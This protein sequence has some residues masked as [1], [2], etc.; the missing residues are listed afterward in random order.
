MCDISEVHSVMGGRN[1]G[2]STTFAAQNAAN[3]AQDDGN[4]FVM[5]LEVGMDGVRD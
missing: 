3:S 4:R 5:N 1:A 2:P